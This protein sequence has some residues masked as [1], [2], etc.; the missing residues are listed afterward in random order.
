MSLFVVNIL[1]INELEADHLVGKVKYMDISCRQ[2]VRE[3]FFVYHILISKSIINSIFIL[4]SRSIGYD[5]IQRIHTDDVT[6]VIMI[7]D[8][9]QRL[10]SDVVL[11]GWQVYAKVTSIQHQIYLQIWRPLETA[12]QYSLVTHILFE[13]Q[14]LRF[15]EVLLESD[16]LIHSGDVIGFY[17]RTHNPIPYSSVPCARSE[18][19]VHVISR[20][21][22]QLT[23]GDT[24]TFS[25]VPNTRHLCRHYSINAIL[26]KY[27]VIVMAMSS[28][29]VQHT[30]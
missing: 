25:V 26:G 21:S 29:F 11:Q 2:D 22:Y 15:N 23:I 6:N 19:F 13:P 1:S 8:P 28:W 18:Q 27:S 3:V 14:K 12:N 10:L 17:F 20:P 16:L 30:L 5:V 9:T 4:V 24:H 7:P